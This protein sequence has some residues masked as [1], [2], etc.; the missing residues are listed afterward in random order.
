MKMYCLV[1][2]NEF[3]TDGLEMCAC[4]AVGDDLEPIE[5]EEGE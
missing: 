1:C 2:G 4:G 5:E 3:E